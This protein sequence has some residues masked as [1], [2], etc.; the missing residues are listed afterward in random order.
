MALIAILI[1]LG[2]TGRSGVFKIAVDHVQVASLLMY[3]VSGS[4]TFVPESLGIA[5]YVHDALH[6]C[7]CNLGDDSEFLSPAT[8]GIVALAA[9]ATLA[10]MLAIELCVRKSSNLVLF[11]AYPT[12]VRD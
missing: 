10:F 11:Y 8:Q 4:V 12:D 7:A 2:P 6:A 9:L 5:D 3:G 1:A